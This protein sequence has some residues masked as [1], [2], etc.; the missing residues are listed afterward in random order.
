MIIGV[1]GVGLTIT[2]VDALDAEQPLVVIV[3]V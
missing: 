1:D 3:T 2:D